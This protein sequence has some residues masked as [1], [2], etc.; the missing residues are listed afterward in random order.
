MNKLHKF[1]VPPAR[2]RLEN[3]QAL[4][5]RSDLIQTS[6]YALS[7]AVAWKELCPASGTSTAVQERPNDDLKHFN[8]LLSLDIAGRGP[9]QILHSAASD[10]Y[11][12]L[13]PIAFYSL[14]P[15]FHQNLFNREQ[16]FLYVAVDMYT[17]LLRLY[18]EGENSQRSD[19]GGQ[20]LHSVKHVDSLEVITKARRFLLHSIAQCPKKSFIHIQQ[21][22]DPCEEFD[23]ELKA[24]LFHSSKLT[25]AEDFY[26]EPVL[27]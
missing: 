8:L 14:T 18:I 26:D 16:T 15:C 6:D 2:D 5:H 3:H 20:S 19:H 23:P 4:L 21:L 11:V 22:L 12:S 10:Q 27:F 9:Y 17:Q 7:P 24:A 25:V 13:L 1:T